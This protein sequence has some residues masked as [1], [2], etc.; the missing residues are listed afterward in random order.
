[1][2]LSSGAAR[3]QRHQSSG[4]G[5]SRRVLQALLLKALPRKKCLFFLFCD[6]QSR[7]L[8]TLHLHLYLQQQFAQPARCWGVHRVAHGRRRRRSSSSGGGGGRDLGASTLYLLREDGGEELQSCGVS[9]MV[10]RP[11]VHA[12]RQRSCSGKVSDA[13]FEIILPLRIAS[14]FFFLHSHP[15]GHACSLRFGFSLF[16]LI[17]QLQNQIQNPPLYFDGRQSV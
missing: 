7:R 14:S 17:M 6:E 9:G 3:Q 16:F 10:A 13:Q 5:P 12:R 15:D 8:S 1:M 11:L 4:G 2:C